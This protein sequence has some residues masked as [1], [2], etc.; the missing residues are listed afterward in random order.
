[1]KRLSG[2]YVFGSA[3]DEQIEIAIVRGNLAFTRSGK[4][5]RMLMHLGSH[6][7]YPAGS[8]ATRIRFTESAG[9]LALTIHDP[10]L[11]LTGLKS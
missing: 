2:T 3:S 1:M 8:F 11:V 10:D 4:T 7:F 5:Q 9:K 6:T